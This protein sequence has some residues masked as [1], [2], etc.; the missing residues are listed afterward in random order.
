ME[1][2]RLL[3]NT[4]ITELTG[5]IQSNESSLTEGK[6]AQ[7]ILMLNQHLPA[8]NIELITG[9]SHR[10]AFHLRKIYMAAG[11]KAICDKPKKKKTLLTK[12]QLREV[13]ETL[14]NKTPL[15]FGYTSEF[16][17]TNILADHIRR[18][19]GVAYKSRTS[20]R[21]LFKKSSFSYH[22]PEKKYQR[23]SEEEVLHWIKEVTPTIKQAWS[24]PSTII[25]VED[26]MILSTQTTTQR[27]WLPTGEYPKIDIATKRENRSLYGFLDIKTGRQ[28][29]FKTMRQNMYQ[30]EAIL[31]KV[32]KKYPRK[33]ILLLWDQ[34]GWHRGSVV[35]QYIQKSS[36][37]IKTIYFPAAAPD[38]NPQEHVWKAGRSNVTHN[39]FI[40]NIDTATDQFVNFLNN[41]KFNYSFLGFCANSE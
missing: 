26:E 23:R 22:K 27:I 1:R 16:W 31:K 33:K 32:R 24:D 4:E 18:K 7:C 30:T 3:T 17:T 35:Q 20:I 15:D 2:C 28:I 10:H 40:E 13:D 25:L 29:C 38:L 36:G 6:K 12:E 41:Q 5:L 34:A 14:K 19:Y 11:I 21:L 39:N 9:Y 37:K 8:Q